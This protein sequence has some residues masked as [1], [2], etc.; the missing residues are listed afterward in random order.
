MVLTPWGEETLISWHAADCPDVG[1]SFLENGDVLVQSDMVRNA[2]AQFVSAVCARLDTEK[3]RDTFLQNEWEA[4]QNCDAEERA[5]CETAAALG[6]DPFALDDRDRRRLVTAHRAIP[7]GLAGEFFAAVDFDSI[8]DAT[9]DLTSCI[10]Q[11]RSA[12][13]RLPTLA[14]LR[15]KF[16]PLDPAEPPWKRGYKFAGLLRSHLNVGDSVLHGCSGVA[17]ALGVDIKALQEAILLPKRPDGFMDALVG[18]NQQGRPVFVIGK[19][20]EDSRQF[21]LCR[22][23][24][25]YLTAPEPDSMA[26][27]SKTRSD[28]QRANRAFAAEFL[29]PAAI[30]QQRLRDTVV[31]DEQIDDL[32]N[33]FGVS[34]FVIRHQIENQNLATIRST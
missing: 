1:V 17:I 16:P 26:L 3:V 9:N 22:S 8:D 20:R 14:D 28:R 23:L 13:V 25:E 2:C 10:A 31:D 4:I 15:A 33:E 5:F 6:L 19:H 27:I 32:A 7:H 11:V 29:V 12:T 21:A 24:Y 18:A 34:C 30:L